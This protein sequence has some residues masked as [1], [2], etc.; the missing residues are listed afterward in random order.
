MKQKKKHKHHPHK[1]PFQPTPRPALNP[2]QQSV[3]VINRMKPIIAAAKRTAARQR[4]R[5]QKPESE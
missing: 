3:E 1:K 5:Q 2:L 4:E